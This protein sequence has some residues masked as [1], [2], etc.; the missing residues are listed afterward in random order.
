MGTLV[1][2]H[3]MATGLAFGLAITVLAIIGKVIGSGVPAFFSGFNSLGSIRIGIGMLPRGEV[4]LIIAGIGLS[5][6]MIENELFGVSIMMTII[7]TVMAPLILVP[8]FNK[9]QSG[10]KNPDAA[11]ELDTSPDPFITWKGASHVLNSWLDFLI[12]GLEERGYDVTL[13]NGPRG[14]TQFVNQFDASKIIVLRRENGTL[15]LDCSSCG[16]G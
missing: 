16:R 5:A 10:L 7:T 14:I 8:L 12:E 13:N 11:K 6:E 3:A 15:A 1:D 9:E 4:A 2:F